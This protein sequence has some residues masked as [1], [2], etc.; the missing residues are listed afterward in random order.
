MSSHYDRAMDREDLGAQFARVA[1]RLIEAE[2]PLLAA[3]R[4][5]MW[6]YVVLSELARGPKPSQL[7]LA[8]AIGHDKSRLIALLDELES[9]GL[10]SRTP[11]ARDR[12]AR[13][14]ALTGAGRRRHRA[15]QEAIHR[16][17]DEMLEGMPAAERRAFVAA[18]RRLAARPD[19]APLS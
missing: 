6:Q 5:T 15:A 4:L 9:N 8:G 10:I 14:I 18:L 1:R 7:E 12:R 11:D 13:V 17:E 16:M 2:R 3:H 19:G